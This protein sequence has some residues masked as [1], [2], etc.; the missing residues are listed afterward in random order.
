MNLL[1]G[2]RCCVRDLR[3]VR[4]HQAAAGDTRDAVRAAVLAG[5][6]DSLGNVGF[7]EEGQIQPVE[8]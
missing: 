3:F 8:G 1:I 6:G 7:F 5:T 4:R 2:L